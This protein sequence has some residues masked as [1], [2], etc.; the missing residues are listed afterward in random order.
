VSKTIL[1]ADNLQ[2]FADERR[3]FLQYAGYK[4]VTVYNPK[5]AER[6][7]KQGEIDLALLDIRLLDDDD[8]EDTSGLALAL[9]FGQAIPIIMLTGYPTWESAKAALGR[10]LNGLSPAVDFLSK[11]E[12]PNLMIQAV[13]L[14]LEHP[15]PKKKLLHKFQAESTQALR[16]ALE[17]K[18]LN[19]PTN[20]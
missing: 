5:D 17:K 3:E 10:N 20:S 2:D 6:I 11:E 8:Q 12:D 18:P 13:N 4:V 1:F 14:T 7:L 19:P 9:R 15:R 16:D